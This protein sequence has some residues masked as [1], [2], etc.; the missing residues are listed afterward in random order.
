MSDL[1]TWGNLQ[2]PYSQEAEE[3]VLGAIITA[4]QRF[5]QVSTFLKAADFFILRNRYVWEAL[6]GLAARDEKIDYLTI[7]EE[8]KNKKRLTEIGGAAYITQLLNSV[9]TSVHAEVYGKLVHTFS[10]RRGL[11]KSADEIKALALNAELPVDDVLAKSGRLITDIQV[12]AKDDSEQS[13]LETAGE[14]F[15]L[16]ERMI[17]DPRLLR[18]IPTGFTEID[19]VLLGLNAPDLIIIAA[20]PGMGKSSY[21]LCMLLNILRANPE[22]VCGLFSL[23]MD[24]K[25]VT[26]RAASISSN[27]NLLTLR[28][29]KLDPKEWRRF[30]KT[31]GDISKYNLKIDD[32]SKLSPQ[33]LRAKCYQWIARHGRLDVIAVD[34][35]QLMSVPEFRASERVQEVAFISRELKN[36]AKEFGV[37]VLAAAQLN[38]EVENRADKRPHLSDLKESGAIEQDSDIVQF[39]YRDDYYNKAST[40]PNQAEIIT[41]KHRNGPT[42]TTPLYFDAPLTKFSD[43]PHKPVHFNSEDE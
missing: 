10:I 17:K 19:R 20:R 1:N 8:L 34:Y 40:T 33:Q 4:P 16:V 24:R 31:M 42:L 30:V 37:P 13:F 32:R 12:G 43:M 39:I 35:L 2:A 3:A 9:P 27:I 15:D 21:L 28:E 25:Q 26:E 14:Y 5:I 38:R 36:L 11:L 23:E 7:C 18:G 6:E 41:A 22:K 29:G